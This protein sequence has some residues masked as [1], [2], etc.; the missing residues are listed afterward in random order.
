MIRQAEGNLTGHGLRERVELVPGDLFG[1]LN[2]NADV[3][4]LKNVLHDWDDAT[5]TRIL[6]RCEPPCPQV[7]ASS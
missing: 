5:C 3:Y 7:L 4:V 6:R 1:E 2:A